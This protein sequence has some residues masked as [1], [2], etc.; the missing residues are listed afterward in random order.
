MFIYKWY[1]GRC[2]IDAQLLAL[3]N[4]LRE[5]VLDHFNTLR[6]SVARGGFSG[7][8]EASRMATMEWDKELAH[9]AVFNVLKCK[10][11]RDKCRNTAEFNN[12]GQSVGYRA[13][14]HRSEP[15]KKSIK[16]TI[17]LWFN[18]QGKTSMDEVLKYKSEYG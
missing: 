10:L 11:N 12:V 18:E 1:G 7:F 9:V 6:D 16:A 5:F 8:T 3:N 14:Y 13:I 2:A 4:E 17:N 15:L